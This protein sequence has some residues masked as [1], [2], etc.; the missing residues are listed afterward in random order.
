MFISLFQSQRLAFLNADLDI[1]RVSLLHLELCT[2]SSPLGA[3]DES[4]DASW[5]SASLGAG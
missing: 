2:G 3:G 4:R 5:M 1:T